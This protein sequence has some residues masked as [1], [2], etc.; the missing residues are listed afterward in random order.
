MSTSLSDQQL[1]DLLSSDSEQAI[2]QIFRQYYTYLCREIYRIKPD[3]RLAEDIAQEVFYELWKKRKRLNIQS[4]LRAYLKRAAVN[5]TLN[6]IRDSKIQLEEVEKAPPQ[7]SKETGAIE[8][9]QEEELRQLIAEAIE[10]LPER[11][12]IVFS[13]SRYENM[14][15]QQIA[16]ELNV[17]VKTVENQIS[18]ALRQLREAI[19][20][21]I[22]RSL[23]LIG[24]IFQYFF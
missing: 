4:S 2:D 11:C 24:V 5:K 6:H 22:N 18:R 13:L 14:S 8:Q 23:M 12:R 15:Y 17:S 10:A 3:A 1:L 16:D 20:P 7:K 19:E 9:L 21:Y